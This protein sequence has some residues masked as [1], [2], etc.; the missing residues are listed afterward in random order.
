[1]K[2]TKDGSRNADK[3]AAGVGAITEATSDRQATPT[4][5]SS[6]AVPAGQ[7]DADSL[8]HTTPLHSIPCAGEKFQNGTLIFAKPNM[9]V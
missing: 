3:T 7:H 9:M 4:T 6:P 1:M 5:E 2:T 8:G